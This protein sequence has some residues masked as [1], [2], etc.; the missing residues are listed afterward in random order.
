M[1][2]EGPEGRQTVTAS[3]SFALLT[4]SILSVGPGIYAADHMS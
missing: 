2:R 1:Q 4:D 3:D